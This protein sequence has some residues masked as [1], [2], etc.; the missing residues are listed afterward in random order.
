MVKNQ[1][2]PD[3]YSQIFRDSQEFQGPCRDSCYFVLWTQVLRIV[4][5]FTSP[6]ILEIGCGTGQLAH[7]LYD[8]GFR[9]YH[10]FDFSPVAVDLARKRVNLS[11]VVGDAE[12]PASF[13]CNYNLVIATEVL[14]HVKDDLG[15]LANLKAGTPVI[16]TLPRTDDPSHVRVFGTLADIVSHY[17]TH[18]AF[19]GI[20]PVDQWFVC[21]G[22]V[23]RFAPGRLN[24]LFTTRQRMD[25]RYV[26]KRLRRL[27]HIPRLHE[28]C[29]IADSHV[30]DE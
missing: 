27:L 16:F 6:R 2:G 19:R 13:D 8:E 5:Q 29:T 1:K 7:Y 28:A 14:E 9:D 18:V 11:F 10:G 21:H 23:G 25:F 12:D 20:I 30:G 24:R 4:R 3:Y 26:Y 15:I 17:Y 22:V